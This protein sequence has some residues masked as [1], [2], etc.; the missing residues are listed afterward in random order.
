MMFNT[1]RFR[2][3]TRPRRLRCSGPRTKL[4]MLQ[5]PAGRAAAARLRVDSALVVG[6]LLTVCT[7]T[8]AV[9]LVRSG[10]ARWTTRFRM[11]WATRWPCRLMKKLLGMKRPV[12]ACPVLVSPR[13]AEV[14]LSSLP[15]AISDADGDTAA[16]RGAAAALLAAP[17]E[18][19][20]ARTTAKDRTAAVTAAYGRHVRFPR[21]IMTVSPSATNRTSAAFGQGVPVW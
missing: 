11:P 2:S 7:G 17:A 5:A 4:R 20:A 3:M 1:T 8:F 13:I 10:V 19:G 18:P 6:M 16:A 14:I 21:W 9:V 15:G 12:T